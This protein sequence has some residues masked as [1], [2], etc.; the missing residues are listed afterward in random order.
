MANTE[1][2]VNMHQM[3]PKSDKPA[4]YRNIQKCRMYPANFTQR[5]LAID[6]QRQ[7]SRDTPIGVFKR[8]KNSGARNRYEL[9]SEKGA[10]QELDSPKQITFV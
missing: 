3:V 4:T 10:R 2:T 9:R 6:H 8:G 5:S 7:A 1:R